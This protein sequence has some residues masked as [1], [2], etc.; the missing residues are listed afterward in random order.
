MPRENLHALCSNPSRQSAWRKRC[1]WFTP[2]MVP[3]LIAIC[4]QQ[5]AA[6]VLVLVRSDAEVDPCRLWEERTACTPYT[7]VTY[8]DYSQSHQ[9]IRPRSAKA[10]SSHLGGRRCI[11]S[12]VYLQ[13][14]LLNLSLASSIVS[15]V[16]HSYNI[17]DWFAIRVAYCG[18]PFMV[19][20]FRF[21][22]LHQEYPNA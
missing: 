7:F 22:D 2:L 12:W 13:S 4:M 17:Y 19:Q 15:H 14:F 6:D 3:I 20:Y 9:I 11:L 8:V 1:L 18:R 10:S 5:H 16:P 21:D